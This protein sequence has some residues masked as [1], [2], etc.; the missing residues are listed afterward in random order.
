MMRF[1]PSGTVYIDDFQHGLKHGKG[2]WRYNR[3]N[4]GVGFCEDGDQIGRGE[5]Q[6]G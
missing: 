3:G 2:T 5:A 4:A 6:H 1:F